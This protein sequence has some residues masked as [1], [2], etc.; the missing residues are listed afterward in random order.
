MVWRRRSA[1]A[2]TVSGSS[3]PAAAS[4]GSSSSGPTTA[5]VASSSSAP[6]VAGARRPRLGTPIRGTGRTLLEIGAAAAI[7]CT[8]AG[9]L[10]LSSG[11]AGH[12]RP[13]V[14]PWRRFP[15]HRA[16]AVAASA[17]ASSA[18]ADAG[19]LAAPSSPTG[20]PWPQQGR[21]LAATSLGAVPKHSLQRA[22]AVPVS[23]GRKR[24][25]FVPSLELFI[26][27]GAWPGD[28]HRLPWNAMFVSIGNLH[29]TRRIASYND[30]KDFLAA[31]S[32]GAGW[33]CGPEVGARASAVAEL[34]RSVPPQ[35]WPGI[36]GEPAAT[37]GLAVEIAF[38]EEAACEHFGARSATVAVVATS[39]CQFG[40]DG[41]GSICKFISDAGADLV[42][43]L[44]NGPVAGSTRP[45]GRIDGRAQELLDWVAGRVG[46]P[47]ID[48]ELMY[49]DEIVAVARVKRTGCRMY[50]FEL[51]REQQFEHRHNARN[52]KL[53]GAGP[54]GHPLRP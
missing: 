24:D 44:D 14:P 28:L 48:L 10:A 43:M 54:N 53:R 16:A 33:L 2:G 45:S 7:A 42:V 46:G 40:D 3:G 31:G 6:A 32:A 1:V 35:A 21:Q 8:S 4:D 5:G 15:F 13:V 23:S 51:Y 25:R 11:T 34:R 41:A 9:P 22:A 20:G 12:R 47:Y 39:S 37:V 19:P 30:K 38:A 27:A 26:V 50:L 52:I 29:G 17:A 36:A 18:V 49:A